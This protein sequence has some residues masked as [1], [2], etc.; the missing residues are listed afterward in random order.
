[1][2]QRISALLL[3][4]FGSIA[5]SGSQRREVLVRVAQKWKW[6]NCQHR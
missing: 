5:G 2:S 3:N 1:M 4:A 6:L